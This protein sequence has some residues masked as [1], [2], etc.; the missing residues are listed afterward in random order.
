ML[1]VEFTVII[2]AFN[3]ERFVARAIESVLSQ[4]IRPEQIVVVDDGSTDNTAAVVREY[5]SDGVEYLYQDNRGL[6]SA[7]NT[8]IRAARGKYIGFLDSDDEWKKHLVSDV[9]GI[10]EKHPNLEWATAPYV[11]LFEN[12]D[13]EFVRSVNSDLSGGGLIEDYFEAEVRFHFSCSSAMFVKR[14][15]FCSVGDFDTSISQYGEDCDMWFRIALTNPRIGY[16]NRI[17]AVY[18]RR[19]GSIMDSDPGDVEHQLMRIRKTESHAVLVGGAA[20]QKSEPLVLDWIWSQMKE[21]AV[22]GNKNA[23]ERISRFYGRRLPI[24]RRLVLDL[25]RI[26]PFEFLWSAARKLNTRRRSL[27]STGFRSIR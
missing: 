17:G 11:K 22:Q 6:A 10:F 21:A 16:C 13:V 15:V 14:E 2:P 19:K 3:E 26:F 20:L 9:K 4:T 8:G 7:R 1:G 18:W 25:F 27:S 12:G 23:L 24:R 5:A